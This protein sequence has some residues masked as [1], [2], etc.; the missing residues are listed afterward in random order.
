MAVITASPNNFSKLLDI[1]TK[2]LDNL[3]TIRTVIEGSADLSA[4]RAKADTDKIVKAQKETAE[5][6]KE[7]TEELVVISAAER[8]A[9]ADQIKKFAQDIQKFSGPIEKLQDRVKDTVEATKK[10]FSLSSMKQRAFQAVNVGGIMDKRIAREQFIEQQ[11]ELGSGK[12]RAE[13]KEDFAQRNELLKQMQKNE[14]ELARYMRATGLNADEVAFTDKG[15]ALQDVKASIAEAFKDTDILADIRS[16]GGKSKG[17]AKEEMLEG[18][19]TE[20]VALVEQKKQTASLEKLTSVFTGGKGGGGRSAIIKMLGSGMGTL[21]SA[22][23]KM[24]EKMAIGVAAVFKAITVGIGFFANPATLI[25]LTAV[26]LAILGLAKAFEIAGPG[27]ES[28][29]KMMKDIGEGIG[30]L[31]PSIRAAGDAISK[32]VDTVFKGVQDTLASIM[33]T[34]REAKMLW[35]GTKEEQEMER[36]GKIAE[37]EQGISSG[38]Y[39]GLFT[40]A[41]DEK[42]ELARLK[43]E[44]KAYERGKKK[45]QEMKTNKNKT[46]PGTE[47]KPPTTSYVSPN[48][49]EVQDLVA[50]DPK[51]MPAV[52]MVNQTRAFQD[53]M[54]D[55]N[56]NLDK[57]GDVNAPV[58]INNN[59]S[60]TTISPMSPRN[61]DLSASDYL[62]GNTGGIVFSA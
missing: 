28:F 6:V 7:N 31:A 60:S 62:Y 27:F 25:G 18:A 22:L 13:L 61:Q 9:R 48:I 10:A 14:E 24:N 20:K 53:A 58:Q 1:Q 57:S 2:S 38:A 5:A 46:A 16:G 45:V 52:D 32:V 29:G 39:E 8:N 34:L 35:Q 3:E 40:D 54:E 55:V 50:S 42:Q 12:S 33:Q 11:Q 19:R 47:K 30:N 43:A 59:N 23:S 56:K 49:G 51:Y 36:L 41:E 17:K 21:V 15:A 4:M 44:Q 37:L 26:T